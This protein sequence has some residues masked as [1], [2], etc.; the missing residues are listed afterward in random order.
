MTCGA[1]R[2]CDVELGDYVAC[3]DI[4]HHAGPSVAV[5][6][7]ASGALNG[8]LALL[9]RIR[10]PGWEGKPQVHDCCYYGSLQSLPAK[11]LSCRAPLQSIPE[12]H[13]S[14]VHLP[15]IAT[16]EIDASVTSE[17]EPPVVMAAR[18]EECA[19]ET[20]R[21]RTAG[22][23]GGAVS[24]YVS[25]DIVRSR[26]VACS[27]GQAA[28][29][30][31]Q[32]RSRQTSATG[33]HHRRVAADNRGSRQVAAGRVWSSVCGHATMELWRGH[34][35][36]SQKGDEE[37]ARRPRAKHC[38]VRQR[39]WRLRAP[40]RRRRERRFKERDAQ[41]ALDWTT[42]VREKRTRRARRPPPL[43]GAAARRALVARYLTP[44]PHMRTTRRQNIAARNRV[45]SGT[46]M[47][48]LPGHGAR[49][50]RSADRLSA[51]APARHGSFSSWQ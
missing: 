18:I 3:R 7:T 50:E 44:A 48:S 20:P 11:P 37:V 19:F 30:C 43:P 12:E 32:T 49:A 46:S 42:Q 26:G 31:A 45:T 39:R 14:E 29:H 15:S 21:R 4:D 9:G 23:L 22:D 34:R 47:P 38:V 16:V 8:D 27:I 13:P 10:A 5:V 6:R 25:R 2:W 33:Q 36:G 24:G 51:R 1:G 35:I 40:R 41:A 17:C 28:G